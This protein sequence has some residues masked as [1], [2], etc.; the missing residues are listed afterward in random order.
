MSRPQRS[1]E[2]YPNHKN[3]PL[4]P[5]KVKDDPKNTPLGLQKVKMPPKL[6]QAQKSEFKESKKMK[7]VQLHEKTPK[8]FL[9]PSTSPKIAC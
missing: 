7:V 6:S 4:G 3:S 8:Q 2:L 9:N 5:P 1:F